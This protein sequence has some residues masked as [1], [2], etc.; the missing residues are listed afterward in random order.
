MRTAHIS[1]NDIVKG[2]PKWSDLISR[3]KYS[4]DAVRFGGYKDEIEIMSFQ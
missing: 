1:E 2:F 4:K 3:H